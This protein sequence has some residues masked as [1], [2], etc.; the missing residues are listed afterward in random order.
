MGNPRA[1]GPE[2]ASTGPKWPGCDGLGSLGD[3]A[4]NVLKQA[5]GGFGLFAVLGCC[6][7]GN[8]G[9]CQAGGI[10]AR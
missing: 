7:A 10:F 8:G 1:R 2:T 9:F 4:C 5:Q 6:L 3:S